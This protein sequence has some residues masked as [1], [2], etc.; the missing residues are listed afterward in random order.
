MS[1]YLF[2]EILAIFF[3]NPGPITR[4]TKNRANCSVNTKAKST[5]VEAAII[6]TESIP[7][8]LVAKYALNG[9]IPR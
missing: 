6:A 5:F 2:L 1:A 8:G 3:D 4:V 7:P 9:S